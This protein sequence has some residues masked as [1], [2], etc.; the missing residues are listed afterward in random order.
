M[1]LIQAFISSLPIYYL[2]LFIPVRVAKNLET[3]M[4]NFLCEGVGEAKKGHLVRWV[5][6]SKS[7]EREVWEFSSKEYFF[8]GSLY[9]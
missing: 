6:E 1:T 5:V 9:L 4:S 8:A 7:R 2:S 3:M